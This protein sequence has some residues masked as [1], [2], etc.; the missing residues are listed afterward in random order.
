MSCLSGRSLSFGI[1]SSNAGVYRHRL[2]DHS[3]SRNRGRSVNYWSRVVD[4]SLRGRNVVSRWLLVSS[5]GL[6]LM[7]RLGN[8]NNVLGH[9][10]GLVVVTG[11]GGGGEER[12]CCEELHCDGRILFIGL[13]VKR[14]KI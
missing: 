2:V 9:R 12:N 3:I 10:L 4:D 5:N 8:G 11:K 14:Q 1:P 13:I 7:D 6:G